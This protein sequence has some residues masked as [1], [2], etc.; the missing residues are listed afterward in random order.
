MTGADLPWWFWFDD[1]SGHVRNSWF[2]ALEKFEFDYR[3][4]W[5]G[6]IGEQLWAEREGMA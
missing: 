2:D 5:W 1:F 3:D 4:E 6:W